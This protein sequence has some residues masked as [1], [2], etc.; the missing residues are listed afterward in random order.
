MEA[1]GLECQNAIFPSMEVYH[2]VSFHSSGLERLT[3]NV[4]LSWDVLRWLEGYGQIPD[5]E[6]N[7]CM[8]TNRYAFDALQ[9]FQL[10]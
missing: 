9:V 8:D 2:G 1:L 5:N 10:L 3:R 6:D 7:T 4:L